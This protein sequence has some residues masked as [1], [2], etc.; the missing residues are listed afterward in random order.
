MALILSRITY[1]IPAWGGQLTR[2]PQERLDA[3][4]KR[5][6]KFG[7]CDENYTTEELLDKA[8]ASLFRLVQRP[9]HCFHRLLPDETV[10]SCSVELRCRDH[11]FPLPQW[12]YNL[13]KN[14]F[15]SRCLFKYV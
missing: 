7:I 14:S 15:I 2:Q 10:H 9:E 13:Y 4:L 6:R 3:L 11:S 12:K 1:A 8:D 5:A